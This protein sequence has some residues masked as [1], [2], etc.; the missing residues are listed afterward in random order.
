MNSDVLNKSDIDHTVDAYGDLLG[1]PSRPIMPTDKA[2]A[3]LR[4]L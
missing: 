1:V 2:T 3:G 4:E